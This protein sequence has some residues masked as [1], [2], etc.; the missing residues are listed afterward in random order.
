MTLNGGTPFERGVLVD[1]VLGRR[2]RSSLAYL[3][4]MSL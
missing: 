1:P 2:S 4:Y 3:S